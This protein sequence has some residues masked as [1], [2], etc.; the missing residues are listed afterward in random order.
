[1]ASN[2]FDDTFISR[3]D[4]FSLGIE[5]NEGIHYASFPVSIGVVDYEEYYRLTLDQY[6]RFM[7]DHE[8]A[9]NFVESCRRQEHDDLLIQKP[10]WN[11]G[12]AI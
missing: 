10:G 3:E 5:I 4:R 8:A 2:R 11:R 1:M 12:A 7:S 9:L 6:E